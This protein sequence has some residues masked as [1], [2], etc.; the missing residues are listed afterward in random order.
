LCLFITEKVKTMKNRIYILLS[1]SISIAGGLTASEAESDHKLQATA[2]TLLVAQQRML[3]GGINP[4]ELND[5]LIRDCEE[6]GERGKIAR[7]RLRTLSKEQIK[8]D[9]KVEQFADDCKLAKE[10]RKISGN[11]DPDKVSEKELSHYRYR[12]NSGGSDLG[13][14]H[15]KEIEQY[16]SGKKT[17]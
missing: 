15:L 17:N 14:E 9:A 13:E 6:G 8:G 1:F 4:G 16:H 7:R 12:K 11:F 10:I 2:N 5:K 3:S